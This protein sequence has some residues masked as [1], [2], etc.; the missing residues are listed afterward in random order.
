MVCKFFDKKTSDSGIKNENIN[1]K[2]A[3]ELHKRIISK[4]NKRKLHSIFI[5]NAWGADLAG[6]QLISKFNKGFRFLLRVV[7]IYSKYASFIPLKIKNE[8]QLLMYFKKSS[9]NQT[10]N[11]IKYG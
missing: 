8:L 10:A 4:F 7:D 9:M 6:I 3:K 2:L 5:D 1:K 11:Q